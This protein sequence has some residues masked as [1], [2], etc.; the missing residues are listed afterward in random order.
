MGYLEYDSGLVWDEVVAKADRMVKEQPV[1]TIIK[2]VREWLNSQSYI[3][4]ISTKEME[5]MISHC[6]RVGEHKIND[7]W[8]LCLHYAQYTHKEFVRLNRILKGACKTC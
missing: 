3:G 4:E 7:V 2:S 5:E 8:W 6:E 1:Q